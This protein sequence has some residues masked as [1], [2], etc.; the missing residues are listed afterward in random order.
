MMGANFNENKTYPLT[1]CCN[2]AI[3]L[4]DTLEDT[5]LSFENQH[6]K[7]MA[8]GKVFQQEMALKL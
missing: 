8:I 3:R 5:T 6:V 4:G 2:P 1:L 7:V